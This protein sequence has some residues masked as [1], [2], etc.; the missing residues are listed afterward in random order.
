MKANHVRDLVLIA[1]VLAIAVAAILPARSPKPEEDAAA[2]RGDE[3]APGP[4]AA[5]AAKGAT[6][7]AK[8]RDGGGKGAAPFA[9]AVFAL[10]PGSTWVYH[11]EGPKELVPDNRW[12]MEVR[13]LPD[14]DV[15][16]EVA[17][18][19][20]AER[21]MYPIWND[22][23]AIR[24]AALPFVEP[25]EFRGSRP[26]EVGGFP[27]PA[28][29]DLGEGAVWSQSYE[30]TGEHEMTTSKGQAVR[31][32]VRGKQ[33]DRALAGELADVTV[34]AGRFSARRVDWTARIELF[35]GKRPVLDPLTAKPFRTEILWVSERVGIVRRR[36]EHSIPD[37]AV[38]T[39]DL[40]SYTI[41][42]TAGGI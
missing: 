39:F 17:V 29:R 3:R 1:A 40:V 27:V 10:A 23:G 30:R 18:G 26:I 8:A 38:V 15:P 13:S 37:E 22:G 42:P 2:D 32:E 4:V 9:D 21:V 12:T 31:V 41:S 25:L 14:G 11:V 6:P 24:L 20:G 28:R 19:F 7:A 35:E 36:V 33:T 5:P 34:P 16:G